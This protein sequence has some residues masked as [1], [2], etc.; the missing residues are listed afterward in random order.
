MINHSLS[1]LEYL[2]EKNQLLVLGIITSTRGNP[3]VSYTGISIVKLIKNE[4]DK[5]LC[6]CS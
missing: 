4:Y 3:G 6:T 1:F 2:H 5:P